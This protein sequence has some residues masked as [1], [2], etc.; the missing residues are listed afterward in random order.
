[1]ENIY[2]IIG[3]IVGLISITGG[4]IGWSKW[5]EG[6]RERLSSFNVNLAEPL[7]GHLNE[8]GRTEYISAK[9]NRYELAENKA[10]NANSEIMEGLL[11]TLPG[12][13]FSIRKLCSRLAWFCCK[14]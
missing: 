13:Y 8:I 3:I 12:V 14:K 1:M 10:L 5:C 11:E 2:I 9:Q 7:T 6:H 4:L